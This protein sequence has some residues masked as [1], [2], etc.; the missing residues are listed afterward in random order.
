MMAGAV[1][2][3]SPV[4]VIEA[5]LTVAAIAWLPV[6]SLSGRTLT[7]DPPPPRV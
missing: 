3:L 6:R 4:T 5:P 2:L 1:A 7:K